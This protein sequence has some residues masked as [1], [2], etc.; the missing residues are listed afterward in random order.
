MYVLNILVVSSKLYSPQ[1]HT[2]V[3]V[4]CISSKLN[5]VNHHGISVSTVT[6]VA[7]ACQAFHTMKDISKASFGFGVGFDGTFFTYKS[8]QYILFVCI[9][10]L[11][12]YVSFSLYDTFTTSGF[13]NLTPLYSS[14]AW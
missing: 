6:H 10:A 5:H 8:I 3:I 11:L 13:S 2:H 14:Q 1:S 4:H 12:L 7:V 9:D